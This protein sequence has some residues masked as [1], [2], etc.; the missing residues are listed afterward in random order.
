MANELTYIAGS[1][2]DNYY[3]DWSG[4]PGTG[5]WAVGNVQGEV[6]EWD[7][8]GAI[9]FE[10]ITGTGN[11]SVAYLKLWVCDYQ[12]GD[13]EFDIYG[14]DEDN[15]SDF[16]SDPMGRDKTTA[17][18]NK[19]L[20]ISS[21]G[22]TTSIEVTSIVNEIRNRGGWSSG[23]AIGFLLFKNEDSDDDVIMTGGPDDVNPKN[24]S[25]LIIRES[26]EPDFTP[27]PISV[28][29]PSFPATDSYGIKISTVGYDVKSATDSQ[30]YLTT[31]KNVFKKIVEGDITTT[32]NTTYNIAHNQSFIPFA[33]AYVKET[34][35]SKR[36]RI[37]RFLPSALYQGQFASLD[38]TNGRIEVDATNVKITTTSNCDVHYYIFLDRAIT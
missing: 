7:W 10:N 11:C 13:I 1:D 15:T 9:R 31:K 2:E 29:A 33:M 38:T 25:S 32:A 26:A 18:V 35:S 27:T 30:A 20:N 12:S 21:Q 28:S 6:L 37:P 36:Y 8:D 14:I 4:N 19:G 22:F 5:Y 24:I 3:K 34:G 16:S 17:T 23:N